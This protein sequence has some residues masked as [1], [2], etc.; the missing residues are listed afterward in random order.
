MP[1]AGDSAPGLHLFLIIVAL[2]DP[3]TAVAGGALGA[4]CR[5]WWQVPIAGALA[6]FLGHAVRFAINDHSAF[7]QFWQS[8][9]H[10]GLAALLWATGAY[11]IKRHL[12]S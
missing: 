8:Y 7:V 4:L 12:R 9:P 1:D 11:T 10:F 3:A 2:G 6:P 5:R